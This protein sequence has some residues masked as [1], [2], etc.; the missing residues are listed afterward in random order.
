MNGLSEAPSWFLPAANVVM[1]L[2]LLTGIFQYALY[3]AQLLVA[4]I[5][6]HRQR[7]QR[8]KLRRFELRN[9]ILPPV[10]VIVPAFN[11]EKLIAD[12]VNSLLAMD[13]AALEVI[14]VDDGSTDATFDVLERQFDLRPIARNTDSRFPHTAVEDLHQSVLYPNLIVIRKPNGGRADAVNAGLAV[15]TAP[16]FCAFDA[17]CVMEPDALHRAVQPFVDAPGE[18]IAVGGTLRVA[19]GAKFVAGRLHDVRLPRGWLPLVQTLEYLRAFLMARLSWSRFNTVICISGAFGVFLKDPVRR[20]AGY[21]R[22][23]AG[24]DMDLVVRLH[25][26]MRNEKR[27]YLIHYLAEPVVWTEVPRSLRAF[28]SQ[29]IR[30]QRGAMEVYFRNADMLLQSRYGRVGWFGLL[31]GFVL[32]VASPVLEVLG[33]LIFPLLWLFG[34]LNADHALAFAAIVFVF[35]FFVSVLGLIIDE[36]ELRRVPGL[37]ALLTLFVVAIFENVGYRQYHN[38][39]RFLGTW[40]Y[41]TGVRGWKNRAW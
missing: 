9:Q 8:R 25:R 22:D 31:H 6:L 23:A 27:D 19:N 16:I 36:I 24:E 41:L 1:W 12:C 28:A 40:Q 2:I 35:G 29:R 15:S 3:M 26:L 7:A 33:Y 14:V 21:S 30:W 37:K 32:D 5:V 4:G 39:C 17:D 11:E 20:I 34:L 38:V 13:Y 10:S 18:V